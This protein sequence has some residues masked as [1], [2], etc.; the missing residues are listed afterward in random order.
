[1]PHQMN[2]FSAIDAADFTP[3]IKVATAV[4]MTPKN[5]ATLE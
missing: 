2:D 5:A 1:M 3:T 4:C